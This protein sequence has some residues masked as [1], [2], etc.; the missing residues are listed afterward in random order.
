MSDERP[1]AMTT[2][3][4]CRACGAATL[5]SVLDLGTVPLANA[6]RE[7][8]QEG[9]PEARFPL[10]LAFCPACSLLQIRET[11]PP[12]ILFRDYVYFSSFSDTMLE[13]ARGLATAFIEQ[14][15]LGPRS[16][17]F[18]IASNDG[19]LLRHF[20]ERG[21]PVLGCEPARNVAKVARERGVPTLEEFFGHDVA[22]R[23]V[24]E[25]RRA[26]AIAGN[27][28]LAHVADLQGV[29]RGVAALLA[30]RG[31]AAFEFPYVLDTIDHVEFDQIY[32]EHLCYFSLHAVQGVFARAGLVLID[33]ER[34]PIHGG[35]L[36]IWLAQESEAPPPTE[37]A[38]A[39]LAH[40]RERDMLD[41]AFYRGFARRVEGLREALLAEL[42]GRRARGE[43][44]AAYGAS[45]KGS[46]LMNVF[47]IG[48][49]TL[50]FV[51]DRSTVK[52]GKLTPGNHL[53][54]VAPEELARRLP[55]AVLLL[56]WNFADEIFR[57]QRAYLEAGGVFI[58]PVPAVRIVGK[59]VLS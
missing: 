32:H 56:T 42:A 53:P 5:E 22:L 11:V 59:E 4:G 26:D 40:E 45:A 29:V 15:Q 44:I 10:T 9:T 41:G 51:A 34:L 39:L 23:L 50:S 7:P 49:E 54:I 25:G 46:T 31:R 30:P 55:D 17:V 28:V 6:L 18:E 58:V 19:Y 1:A 57:Q 37:R 47:G 14:A 2:I 12:E 27:N 43:T 16:L 48:R 3:T 20:V 52:Q 36:R 35:S 33:A 21:I 13:H 8:G 38:L 24:A